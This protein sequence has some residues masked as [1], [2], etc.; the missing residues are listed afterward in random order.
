MAIQPDK[1]APVIGARQRVLIVMLC[2]LGAVLAQAAVFVHPLGFGLSAAPLFVLTLAI[3]FG[4]SYGLIASLPAVAVLIT[5]QSDLYHPVAWFA[6]PVEAIIIGFAARRNAVIVVSLAVGALA[7]ALHGLL[8]STSNPLVLAEGFLRATFGVA[9]ALL[10]RSFVNL[11]PASSRGKNRS[12][13]SRLWRHQ[14]CLVLIPQLLLA[15]LAFAKMANDQA[16]RSIAYGEVIVRSEADSLAQHLA[17][18]WSSL[19][20]LALQLRGVDQP[21]D[22]YNAITE[23]R[24]RYP[25]LLSVSQANENGRILRLAS[26]RGASAD[27]PA[28][29]AGLSVTDRE[30]FQELRETGQRLLASAP[31]GQWGGEGV[32]AT[33]AV[34]VRDPDGRFTGVLE[35]SINPNWL[36]T[37]LL[38]TYTEDLRVFVVDSD[39]RVLASNWADIVPS[40]GSGMQ[41]LPDILPGYLDHAASAQVGGSAWR[42][43]A[44]QDRRF[45]GDLVRDWCIL[46]GILSLIS[47][48]LALAIVHRAIDWA[49][50]PINRI[51]AN[52]DRRLES[53]Q[54]VSFA[55]LQ[56]SPRIPQEMVSFLERVNRLL[57]AA[58][59]SQEMTSRSVRV[60]SGRSANDEQRPRALILGESG[61]CRQLAAAM[62]QHLGY[63]VQ[64]TSDGDEARAAAGHCQFALVLST[65]AAADEIASQM[66]ATGGL[67]AWSGDSGASPSA[68]DVQIVDFPFTL[69]DLQNLQVEMNRPDSDPLLDPEALHSWLELAG[70]ERQ[71]IVDMVNKA[72]SG[73]RQT[74]VQ[75]GESWKAGDFTAARELAHK[76]RG[77][78]SSYGIRRMAAVLSE[79]EEA[80]RREDLY[81]ASMHRQLVG[82]AED[83]VIA[84][85]A[86]LRKETGGH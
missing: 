70:D 35:A 53:E 25:S 50:A 5:L 6:L 82:V 7:L 81:V 11:H 71:G 23:V 43:V 15:G 36:Q 77:S 57:A 80:L 19:E 59:A 84:V 61:A 2:I 32:N 74:A 55:P 44:Y 1:D 62:L 22:A 37:T 39:Q 78:L 52:I 14:L 73:L 24:T 21:V 65:P 47:I 29:E 68:P 75:I 85:D 10:A 60:Q 42:V 16:Q 9:M 31:S 12:L 79:V 30:G 56:F 83:T 46:I 40:T 48:L 17:D 63:S 76:T 41:S 28:V 33:I 66:A 3:A 18:L 54:S 8:F 27:F 64:T 34:P 58:A 51:A 20:I 69:K 45:L 72:M 49:I 4:P 26:D 67:V 86:F 13:K 38:E